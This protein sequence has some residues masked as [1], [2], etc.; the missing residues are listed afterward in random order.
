MAIV[1][2][3]EHNRN[4]AAAEIIEGEAIETSVAAADS[5]NAGNQT[6]LSKRHKGEKGFAGTV[7]MNGLISD[8]EYNSKLEGKEGL[9]LLNQ[10]RRGDATVRALLQAVKQPVL[11]AEW[12]V[13]E[14]PEADAREKE[15]TTRV[16]YCLDEFLNFRQWLAEALNYLDF[17]HHVDEKVYDYVEIDGKPFIGLVKLGSRKQSSIYAW[18]TSDGKPGIHQLT[19]QGDQADVPREKLLVIVNEQEGDNYEGISLLRTVYKPWYMKEQI[20][21]V[22][23]LA[24][25]KQG[26]GIPVLTPPKGAKNDEKL[27]ARKAIQNM[28]ANHK[29]YLELPDGWGVEMLD[30]KAGTR[31]DPMP[32]IQH[33]DHQILKA[34]L[35]QF[36]DMGSHSGSGGTQSSSGDQSRLLY[37]SLTS[38]A[39]NVA[40]A[41]NDD[42]IKQLIDLNYSNVKRYPKLTVSKIA[43][44]DLQAFATAINSLASSK[45]IT[46]D[47]DLEQSIREK[48]HLP[49]LPEEYKNDYA[50]R[51]GSQV[52]APLDPN[53]D[54]NDPAATKPKQ[55][56]NKV[57]DNGKKDPKDPAANTKEKQASEVLA[58]AREMHT[59]LRQNAALL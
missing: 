12:K 42:V 48:F 57:K 55:D 52:P 32:F 53:A 37:Q 50:N 56:P 24:I 38:V 20:Y 40:E 19:S 46:P 26:L 3:M 8:E 33:L 7:I 35:V 10:M 30:M 43:S 36:I 9:E 29:N 31:T 1:S 28:R 41:F 15:M 25:E 59:L 21:K 54:P 51:P 5:P 18:E 2:D 4:S 17:G 47:A 45:L 34:G 11:D 13:E 22:M 23:A 39:N 6:S 27:A 58:N 14:P 49:D 16:Q 44:E